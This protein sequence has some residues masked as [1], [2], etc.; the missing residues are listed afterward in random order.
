MR[1]IRIGTQLRQAAVLCS[2]GTKTFHRRYAKAPPI[3]VRLRPGLLLVMDI[4]APK[5]LGLHLDIVPGSRDERSA[6]HV[7]AS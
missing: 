2:S 3:A 7:Y 1:Q 5:R 6:V 4:V